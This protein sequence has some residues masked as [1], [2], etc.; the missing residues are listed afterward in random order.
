MIVR[1][2]LA[3]SVGALAACFNAP[4]FEV[5]FRCASGD[6]PACP[7]GYGCESDLCC[8]KDGSDIETNYGAC[9]LGVGG[10]SGSGEDS[11]ENTASGTSDTGD[12]Q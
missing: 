7:P 9:A 4:A 6:E 5:M 8:H 11:G 12:S 10:E 3:M 2:A 1:L